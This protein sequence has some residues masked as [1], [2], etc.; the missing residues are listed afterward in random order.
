MQ[1]SIKK[2]IT[3]QV[4]IFIV[5]AIITVLIGKFTAY[6][7]GMILLLSGIVPIAFGAA[8]NAGP[9]YR[10][11]PYVYN[12]SKASVSER[13]SMDKKEMLSQTSFLVNCIII[14]IVPIVVGLLLMHFLY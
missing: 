13:H 11:M 8:R 6:K 12:Q 3:I 4:I 10:P 9:R 14:G 5:A 7:Y 1:K 2:I